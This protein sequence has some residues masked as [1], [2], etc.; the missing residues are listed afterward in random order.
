MVYLQRSQPENACIRVGQ[1]TLE[2]VCAVRRAEGLQC[3]PQAVEAACFGSSA[4]KP[5]YI[6]KLAQHVRSAKTPEGVQALLQCAGTGLG[7]AEPGDARHLNS[8]SAASERPRAQM[9]STQ[10][11]SSSR[12]AE[13]RLVWLPCN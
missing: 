13:L 7:A 1:V 3:A 12:Y 9:M 5:V 6:S 4:S 11:D 8:Q 2:T 10:A